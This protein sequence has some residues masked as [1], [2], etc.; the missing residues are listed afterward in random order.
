MLDLE[1]F[2]TQILRGIGGQRNTHKIIVR[3]NCNVDAPIMLLTLDCVKSYAITCLHR[4][5]LFLI[6]LVAQLN[7]LV[8]G[9]LVQCWLEARIYDSFM[10]VTLVKDLMVA[11]V[12]LYR[13]KF[14]SPLF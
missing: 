13:I 3:R 10:P 2:R 11:R 9:Q 7:P 1:D 5:N 6:C 4:S 8:S 12:N 14:H